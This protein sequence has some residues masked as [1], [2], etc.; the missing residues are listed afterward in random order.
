LEDSVPLLVAQ[1]R[2]GNDAA[3]ECLIKHY[4]GR[5]YSYIAR[6]LRDPADAEDLAQETFVRAYQALPHFR[7]DASFQTWLYRIAANLTIDASRR[8]LRREGNTLSLDE[9]REDE[10]SMLS[11]DPVDSS[12]RTPVEEVEAGDVRREVW[13]AIS[14]LSPK[15]RPVVI[16]Y[17]LQGLSYEE[18]ATIL[19]CPLGTVKSRLF[20]ARCQLR[21]KLRHRL[22]EEYF[23]E[24]CLDRATA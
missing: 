16:L 19:G 15:L 9:P 17:D 14:E 4:Q 5:I 10:D 20:N 22:P 6:M 13:A 11:R 1:A 21:D 18:I 23:Q 12:S 2:D 7:G 3:F 8:R 24:L